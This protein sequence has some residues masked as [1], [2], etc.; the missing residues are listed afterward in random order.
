MGLLVNGTCYA[1]SDAAGH[2]YAGL[3]PPVTD[4]LP[5]GLHTYVLTFAGN[6]EYFWMHFR[7]DQHIGNVPAPNNLQSCDPAA[8]LVD[9]IQLG[10]GVAS[11]ILAAALVMVLKRGLR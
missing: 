5:D 7:D 4:I 1:D 8:N 3:T 9:G 10:W 6:S 11:V 2:L